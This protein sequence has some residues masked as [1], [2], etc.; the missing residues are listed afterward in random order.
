L[1]E[2]TINQLSAMN[3]HYRFYELEEFF[4]YS[5]ENGFKNVEI[6][7]GPQ[8]YFVDYLKYESVDKIKN[9]SD[10]YNLNIICICPEQTNPKPNNIAIK[11]E[12]RQEDV[13]RYFKNCIDISVAIG[14]NMVLITS[15][16]SYYNEP[17]KDAWKRSALMLTKIA[18]YAE[19]KGVYLAMEAL[20][21]SESLIVNSIK[22]LYNMLSEVG[23]NNLKVC[24]DLG[25]CAGAGE[26]IDEYFNCFK[27]EI[28]HCHFVDGNPTGH[29]AWG[30]GTRNM[31]EDIS[32]FQ[33]NDYQGYLSFEFA[34]SRYFKEPFKADKKS[35]EMFKSLKRR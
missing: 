2:I 9:L 22:S 6:W 18:K 30:D 31:L 8:H 21:V 28:I 23:N 26:T 29:L 17:V 32:A 25:A 19:K 16:W 24:I 27:K 5:R 14:C 15:G 35:I 4:R 33:K 11:D 10:K 1:E 12:N 13:Y 3:C 7:T 34:S 20:Q